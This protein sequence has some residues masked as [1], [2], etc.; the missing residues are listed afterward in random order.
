MNGSKFTDILPEYQ[1]IYNVSSRESESKIT[2][3]KLND[4]MAPKMEKSDL[5]QLKQ[6]A[7]AAKKKML[8]DTII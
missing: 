4:E 6:F 1:C 3:G 8:F 7:I 5:N 2:R